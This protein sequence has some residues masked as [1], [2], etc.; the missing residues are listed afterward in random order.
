MGETEFIINRIEGGYA[1]CEGKNGEVF[2]IPLTV[3]NG[4]N[5]GDVIHLNVD[6]A[7]TEKRKKENKK[8]L[9][10]LFNKE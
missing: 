3:L 10:S 6:A 5:E 2:N 7:E 1:V 4:V 9:E 8:R